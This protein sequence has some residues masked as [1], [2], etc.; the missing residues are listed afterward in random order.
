M[1]DF[2]KSLA[3]SE[4]RACLAGKGTKGIQCNGVKRIAAMH[5]GLCREVKQ[6]A[7]RVSPMQSAEACSPPVRG[8]SIMPWYGHRA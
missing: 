6:S 7:G 8:L 3:I 5:T 2:D 1:P 4:C